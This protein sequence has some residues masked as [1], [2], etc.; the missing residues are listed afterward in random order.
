MFLF[1]YEVDSL[2]LDSVFNYTLMVFKI[3]M[4]CFT[5]DSKLLHW[6]L[7]N[8]SN[9]LAEVIDIFFIIIEVKGGPKVS[10]PAVDEDIFFFKFFG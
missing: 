9:H 7:K 3:F 10:S 4:A 6:T 5:F 2:Y 8:I 1:H